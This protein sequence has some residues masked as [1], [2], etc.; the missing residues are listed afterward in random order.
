M[1][2]LR[3]RAVTAGVIWAVITIVLGLA[4]LTTYLTSQS[5]A[6]F[7]ELLQTRHTQA[8]VA[9]ANS[10]SSPEQIARAIGDPVYQRPFSGQYWQ[11]ESL[12]GDLIVSPSLVDGLL[13]LPPDQFEGP[14]TQEIVTPDG[15]ELMIIGQWLTMDDGESWYVQVASS[16]ETLRQDEAVLR[17]SLFFAFVIVAVIAVVGALV[18]VAAMLQPL[19]ALRADVAARWE[20]EEGLQ[21][22][23]YPVEVAPL[24]NDINGL[25]ERNRDIIKGS[26]KQAADLAHAIKTPAAIMRNEL[27]QLQ[28]AGRDV[29]DALA[30]LDRLDAQLQ[31]S[32]ARMRADGGDSSV[33]VITNLDTSLGRM[34]RAFTALARNAGRQFSAD[35]P[36]GLR[37]RM[38]QSDL[39]EVI[40]NILDNAMKWS[41]SAFRLEAERT[42]DPAVRI[43]ISDD[44]PGVP[45]E[46]LGSVLRSGERLDQS[47]PGTGLGL[48][49]ASDLVTAYGGTIA[50]GRSEDLGGLMV[51]LNLPVPGGPKLAKST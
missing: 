3:A 23:G 19:N 51:S 26:R 24:V 25:L 12:D 10:A 7:I 2:S 29:T 45:E 40:G 48:A 20:H 27:E 33:G 38:D 28:V 42:D 50:L 15:E 13:P 36:E 37:V 17:Q 1:R 22:T 14:G 44:G 8:L 9:V 5:E 46:E 31:R 11:A 6:R 43:I 21:V 32:L 41:N 34:Q 18:Q 39:E 30:A 4:G 47:K 35:V 16:L 49:I